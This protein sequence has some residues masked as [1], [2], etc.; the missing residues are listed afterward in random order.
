MEHV[1]TENTAAS[2]LD[3]VFAPGFKMIKWYVHILFYFQSYTFITI[4]ISQK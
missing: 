3:K 1:T 2:I 4:L